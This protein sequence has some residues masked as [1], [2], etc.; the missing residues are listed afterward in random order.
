ML[1]IAACVVAGAAI[2]GVGIRAGAHRAI[3]KIMTGQRMIAPIAA[4]A[5]PAT[6]VGAVACAECHQ[7]EAKAWKGSHH[8]LAMQIATPATVLGNFDNATFEHFGVTTTF[9]TRS[10]KFMVRTDGPDGTLGEYEVTHT[11]GVW[12]LQQYLV[13]FP[14]GRFQALPVAWDSR[15]K[16]DGGQHWFHLFPNEA[17]DHTDQLHWTGPYQNWNLM[18][19]ECHSTN[20]RKGY[21]A[22]ANTYTTTFNEINV[23]C[24]ACHGPGSNHIKWA[25]ATAPPYTPGAANGLTVSLNSRWASAWRFESADAKFPVRDTPPDAAVLDA[26]AACHA[27]RSTIKEGV[28][29]GQPLAQ[30]HRL[31]NLVQPLYH[32]DGQQRDEVYVW[33]SFLQSRMHA[34]GVTCMDCHEPHS[35]KALA[36]GN[37]VCARCHSPAIFDAPS[38]HHH[39]VDGTGAS[40]TACHMPTQ[41]YMVIHER[42]DHSIRVPRPD[43]AG[44]TGAPDA[45]TMCHT[46][47][48]PAWAAQAM[49]GWYP[50][51]WRKRTE[52]GTTLAAGETQG[53]KATTPLM[54]MARDASM[55]AIVRA[56]AAQLAGNYLRPQHL[57]D[58]RALV[59]D[60][61]PQ[62]RIAA[63][64]LLENFDADVRVSVGAACLKDSIR[65]VRI[66]AARLLGDIPSD[67]LKKEEASA[68]TEAIAEYEAS[69]ALNADW[70]VENV[71]AG[72]FLARRGR[73]E[74]A[75]AAYGRAIKL[76]RKFAAAY[77]NLADLYRMLN[78]DGEGERELRAGLTVLPQSADLH[79]ALGLL[80]IRNAR[81]EDG[82]AELKA[83]HE[84]APAN[85]RYAYVYAVGLHSTGKT[86]A[87]L[88]V[89]R[90]ANIGHPYDPD[91]LSAFLSMLME[92]GSPADA[93]EALRLARQLLEATPEDPAVRGLVDRLSGG[94]R[95]SR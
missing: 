28:A 27:R 16:A 14:G 37:Q 84:L 51:T 8:D 34:K 9:F 62:V 78:R 5:G 29:P 75:I 12:P 90:A 73:I 64:D 94:T 11:F 48:T 50:P 65:G 7:E 86:D 4:S 31:S 40:C 47:K 54:A 42:L 52:W 53:A 15:A 20:L 67:K 44:A 77:V 56:T 32:A 1:R 85:A 21:D 33:G 25:R 76:D 72:T 26:C 49:D 74:E 38:H 59:A 19:A 87:A 41:K 68:L 80:L 36:P 92:R 35:L 91:I 18:C 57:A 58:I 88:E 63:I 13:P 24:E 66:A 46:D 10:G 17:I 23:A 81:R 70:P 22:K 3:W 2:V 95:P 61:D 71:N 89:V 45:C 55:P 83:A 39:K 93:P 30:S 60:A 6:F 69:L 82:L 43:L 79:H